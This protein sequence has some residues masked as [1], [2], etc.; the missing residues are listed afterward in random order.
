MAGPPHAGAIRWLT[1]TPLRGIGSTPGLRQSDRTRSFKRALESYAPAARPR[2]PQRRPLQ[3][4]LLQGGSGRA[5]EARGPGA[6]GARGAVRERDGCGRTHRGRAR[7]V[8]RP[9]G[10]C[11]QRASQPALAGPPHRGRR[12]GARLHARRV[13]PLGHDRRPHA[14][15]VSRPL[16]RLQRKG[17]EVVRGEVERVDPERR[18]AVVG[19]Q[20]LHGDRLI[21]T[22]R[23]ASSLAGHLPHVDASVRRASDRAP[24]KLRASRGRTG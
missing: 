22:A 8:S 19:G 13:V 11:G 5:R 1:N 2:R 10:G 12:S 9:E 16:H 7:Q 14:G 3:R 17:I 15:Q 20:T 6:R 4:P 21:V 18:E 24:R 23:A